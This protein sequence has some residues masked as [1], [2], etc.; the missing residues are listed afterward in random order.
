MFKPITGYPRYSISMDGLIRKEGRRGRVMYYRGKLGRNGYVYASLTLDGIGKQF[1]MHRLVLEMWV[2]PCPEGYEACHRNGDRTDNRLDNLYWG[3]RST[4]MQ[5]AV[6]HGTLSALS[7]GEH[8][9][10][11]KYSDTLVATL[12][13]EP[14]TGYGFYQRM[15]DKY[16]LPYRTVHWLYRERKGCGE[17]PS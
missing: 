15:A 12:R 14:Y 17:L 2:G 16:G 6:T 5:D 9:N 11:A 3:T 1:L 7:I 8:H 13:A 4:N 10:T